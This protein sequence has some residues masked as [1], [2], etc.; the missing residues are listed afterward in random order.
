MLSGVGKEDP[1]LGLA[2]SNLQIYCDYQCETYLA[3]GDSPSSILKQFQ[4]RWKTEVHTGMLLPFD[5]EI[6]L[7][8]T[9]KKRSGL[10]L[11]KISV[12]IPKL[13]LVADHKQ[14]EVL[15]QIIEQYIRTKKRCLHLVNLR[16]TFGKDG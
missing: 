14:L 13:R 16:A 11:P 12:V 2:V 5:L 4:A 6:V 8:V 3:N 7:A 1:V 10:V 9:I 15:Q